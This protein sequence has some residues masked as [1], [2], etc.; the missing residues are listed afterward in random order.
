MKPHAILG[1]ALL[2]VLA[3]FAVIVVWALMGD[4][5]RTY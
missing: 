4:R 5:P 3:V 1:A 2:L